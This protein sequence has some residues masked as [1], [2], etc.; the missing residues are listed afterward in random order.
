M[1]AQDVLARGDSITDGVADEV[2]VIGGGMVGCETA[3]FLAE[4]GKKVT[5]V[6][7]LKRLAADMSP[8]VR[9]RLMDG[10]RECGVA[11]VTKVT[12]REITESGVT[13]T[14]AEGKTESYNAGT[15]IVAV[16]YRPDDVLAA[17][18]E[19]KVA[20]VVRIGDAAQPGRIREAIDAGHRAGL[21]L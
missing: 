14:T 2:V 15:V 5:I 10:L 6:E 20:E 8:M 18:L 7:A 16:G 17:A 21:A 1:T 13:V 11:M 19:D 3:H 12:C 9:R 4:A